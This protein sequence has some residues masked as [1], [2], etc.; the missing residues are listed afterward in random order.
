M[1]E[2]RLPKQV[3]ARKRGLFLILA[4]GMVFSMTA[5]GKKPGA[6]D[7]PPNIG[8]D[9]FPRTYPDPETDPKP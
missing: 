3:F 4:L 9:N 1:S 8:K 7:P 2:T 5:C 6:V